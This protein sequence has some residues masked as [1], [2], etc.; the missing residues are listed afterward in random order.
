M[1]VV[2]ALTL[3]I[4][5]GFIFY[6][7]KHGFTGETTDRKALVMGVSFS[8]GYG[9]MSQVVQI[10]LENGEIAQLTNTG[11]LVKTGQ[12]IT[13]T[14]HHRKSSGLSNYKIKIFNK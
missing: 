13:V 2:V 1:L 7:F 14:E 9:S 11:A 10:K 4:F 6:S 12:T 5:S 3:I 8:Q